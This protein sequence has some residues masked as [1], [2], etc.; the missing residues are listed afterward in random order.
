MFSF[1]Y[2]HSANT[3]TCENPDGLQLFSAGCNKSVLAVAITSE[4][5]IVTYAA[6]NPPVLLQ[7][8]SFPITAS[9]P[10]GL[11]NITI[12]GNSITGYSITIY[13]LPWYTAGSYNVYT[14]LLD[15]LDPCFWAITAAAL[16]GPSCSALKVFTTQPFFIPPPSHCDVPSH[17]WTWTILAFTCTTAVCLLATAVLICGYKHKTAETQSLLAN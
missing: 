9:F 14:A 1:Q 6:L 12:I 5:I 8:I 7:Q 3:D 15:N 4:Q 10:S 13:T 17:V 16:I 11:V 2:D